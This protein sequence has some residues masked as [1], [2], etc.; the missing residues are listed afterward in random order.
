MVVNGITLRGDGGLYG[1][2]SASGGQPKQ[3][4]PQLYPR[5][6]LSI[7]EGYIYYTNGLSIYRKRLDASDAKEE[8]MGVALTDV[9]LS[10]GMGNGLLLPASDVP[11]LIWQTPMD[12]VKLYQ[13][14]PE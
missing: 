5:E 3:V 7:S 6:F 12:G 13:Y 14:I 10:D 2:D 9:I 8:C 1:V 4:F 11:C